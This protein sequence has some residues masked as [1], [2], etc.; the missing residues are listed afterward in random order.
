MNSIASNLRVK[1][2]TFRQIAIAI[3]ILLLAVL[4][5]L[6]AMYFLQ[7]PASPA[8]AGELTDEAPPLPVNLQTIT[9]VDSIEQS[10]SYT[11]TVRPKHRSELAFELA[12][13]II[14]VEV[15]EGD[16]VEAG[17]VIAS[18]DT[19]T[20]T[21]Q[22]NAVVA[23]LA[24]ANSVLDELN[25]GPRLEKIKSAQADV[26]A[27]QSELENTLQRL[28][29]R[30]E[31]VRVNAIPVEEFRQAEF[32]AKTAKAMLDSA[33]QKLDELKAGTRLEKVAAQQATVQSLKA[34][35]EEVD[36]AIAKS[37][38]RAPFA[39]TVTR[40]Y[41][42]PGS[43]SQ[44]SSPVVKLVDDRQLEGWVGLP[45]KVASEIEVG[46]NTYLNIEGR[47][48]RAMV[49][50]RIL[51][52]DP[53]TRTQA[54][55]YDIDPESAPRLVAGQLC[56]VRIT[57]TVEASGVWIPNSALSKGVRGL[58]SVFTVS[59]DENGVLRAHKRDISIVKTDSDRVL[60]EGTVRD[61]D[62]LVVDGVH[63]I[64]DGQAVSDASLSPQQ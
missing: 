2:L 54:I 58:W 44:P 64:T 29:R 24:Q 37:T 23:Q 11:G 8:K 1:F 27:L 62:R 60:A 55:V 6:A 56:K 41:V 13:K 32:A 26:A 18:L 49:A 51:E 9:F 36:V 39:A 59:K 17:Q 28:E 47:Q 48:I 10:R 33:N 45:A 46:D 12:G 63:R 5:F 35:L 20:L 57:S 16:R 4:G 53:S 50:A 42:D 40:R 19:D 61:G 7:M 43:I 22:R 30:K 34:S 15:E 31:L 21:A 3:A 52:I 14:S 38:L 25:A